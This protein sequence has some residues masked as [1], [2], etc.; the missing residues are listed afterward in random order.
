MKGANRQM[1]ISVF[2]IFPK[3]FLF[4]TNGP[5]WAQKWWILITLDPFKEYFKTFAQ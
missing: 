1:I 3:R 2:M 5:F 4:G